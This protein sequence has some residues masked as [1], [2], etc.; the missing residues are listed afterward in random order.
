LTSPRHV[1]TAHRGCMPT[2]RLER[3]PHRQQPRSS[4]HSRTCSRPLSD[5]PLAATG[6]ASAVIRLSTTLRD[7]PSGM[8][9]IC[10]WSAGP[11]RHCAGLVKLLRFAD[12]ESVHRVRLRCRGR[13]DVLCPLPIGRCLRYSAASSIA[14]HRASHAE[15]TPSL[16]RGRRAPASFGRDEMANKPDPH[17]DFNLVKRTTDYSQDEAEQA[18]DLHSYGRYSDAAP[19]TGMEGAVTAD[20][21]PRTPLSVRFGAEERGR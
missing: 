6:S 17:G 14:R 12:D 8:I 9:R 13:E 3:D 21:L 19:Q 1:R 10:P 11:P 20:R 16:R 18:Q 7:V 15:L 5:H 2:A 4:F